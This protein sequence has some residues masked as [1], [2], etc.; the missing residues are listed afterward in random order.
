MLVLTRHLNEAIRI[1][2]GV[3]IKVLSID[4]NNVKIG[5]EAPKNVPV[6][7]EEIYERIKEENLSASRIDF[8][9][10]KHVADKLKEHVKEKS[11]IDNLA[12]FIYDNEKNKNIISEVFAENQVP[13]ETFDLRRDKGITL[14]S[15]PN[16]II[17]NILSETNWN[18]FCDKL[19]SLSLKTSVLALN[20]PSNIKCDAQIQKKVYLSDDFSDWEQI[21]KQITNMLKLKIYPLEKNESSL[22]LMNHPFSISI[23]NK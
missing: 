13:L 3:T 11:S 2:D 21:R 5:I 10:I 7:R 16:L 19:D 6:F 8:E 20:I 15:M 1:G 23:I 14:K 9:N 17:L 4:S 22:V 12:L 18:I